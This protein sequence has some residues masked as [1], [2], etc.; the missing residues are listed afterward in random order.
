MT[1]PLVPTYSLM[2]IDNM[3][4]YIDVLDSQFSFDDEDGALEAIRS[5]PKSDI[6]FWT[7]RNYVN[8]NSL[9]EALE[10][11]SWEL[12]G[13]SM[14]FYGEKLSGD[15]YVLFGAIAPF[16]SSGSYIEIGG[17][18]Y[19]HHWKWVF[20]GSDWDEQELDRIPLDEDDD[21]DDAD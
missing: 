12:D 14:N 6:K 8:A 3:G 4:F 11:F 20:D 9:D 13:N 2:R 17:V 5:I 7:N 18:D 16:V 10:C 19:G 15:D 1:D 21:M